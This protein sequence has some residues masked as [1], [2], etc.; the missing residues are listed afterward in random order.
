MMPRGSGD[1]HL[2]EPAGVDA[3]AL[4]V[5]L[6]HALVDEH[7]DELFDVKQVS[8]STSDD[9]LTQ[10]FRDALRLPQDL[11]DQLPALALGQGPQ[12]DP[13]VV[14]HALPHEGRR[15]SELCRARHRTNSLAPA[16]ARDLIHEVQRSVIRPVNVLEQDDGGQLL[17]NPA[18]ELGRVAQSPVLI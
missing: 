18:H 7:L 9:H 13:L 17:G 11:L 14:G 10:Y 2:D 15:S 5:R 4:G 12:V 16:H 1:P 6:D 3:P 8:F